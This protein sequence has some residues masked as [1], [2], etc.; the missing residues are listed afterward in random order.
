M[1]LVD[2][3]EFRVT[4]KD[5]TRQASGDGAQVRRRGA[6]FPVVALDE[7]AA[8]LREAAK[9]GF[10]HSAAAFG[11]YMGHR[12]TNSGAFRRR[13]AAFRDWGLITGRG[14]NI[15]M[16]ENARLIARPPDAATERR[17]LRSA[18][19]NCSIFARLYEESQKDE[20]LRLEGLGNRAIHDSGVSAESSDSFVASFVASA[21]TAGLAERSED[22]RVILRSAETD[23]DVGAGEGFGSEVPESSVPQASRPTTAPAAIASPPVVSQVWEIDDVS[24]SF[25]IRSQRPLPAEVFLQVAEVVGRLE[26]L[27]AALTP[28]ASKRG[29]E[30]TRTN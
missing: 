22:G 1:D 26:A 7:A 14:D 9:Y 29:T 21:V 4:G 25:E 3:R 17:A 15:A 24:I 5:Q 28:D 19:G 8:I 23:H 12:S 10:E 18:F 13:L 11:G 16:T 27:A 30:E 2:V 6:G 20:P